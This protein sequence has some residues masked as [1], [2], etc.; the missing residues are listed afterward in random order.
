MA[1][2][3]QPWTGSRR[4]GIG[5]KAPRIN[6]WIV[7]SV[8]VAGIGASLPVVQASVATSRG[9]DSQLLDAQ[10]AALR[11]EIRLLESDVARLTSA[12]RIER[13]A[14]D[15]GLEPATDPI[16]VE[17]AV[18]GP[19]PAKIPAEYLPKGAP[20]AANPESWWQSLFAWIPLPR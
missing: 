12:D 2:L 6:G 15:I 4:P 16:Y 17:V 11:S 19:A 9:F 18:P 8:L 3:Q 10:Q 7:A 1:T 5:I 14:R 13:R 20:P